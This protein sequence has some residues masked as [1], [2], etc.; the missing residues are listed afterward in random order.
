MERPSY[1]M[2]LGS[3]NIFGEG[4]QG[5]EQMDIFKWYQTSKVWEK[6]FLKMVETM[7]FTL[8]IVHI[9]SHAK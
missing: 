3:L 8:Y 5:E 1:N 9:Q 4:K 7:L 2:K 6:K